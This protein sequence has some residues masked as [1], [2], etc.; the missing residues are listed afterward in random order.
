MTTLQSYNPEVAV[1]T[2]VWA[3]TRSLATTYVITIVF[4]SSAYLDVSV[5]RVCLLLLGYLIFN[6]VG[7]PIRKSADQ[8]I[9]ADPRSLSQLITSFFASESLGILHTPLLTFFLALVCK[10]GIFPVPTDFL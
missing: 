9:C 4:S 3:L 1:T 7:C 8:F 5:Q 10:D 2:P 6:Q